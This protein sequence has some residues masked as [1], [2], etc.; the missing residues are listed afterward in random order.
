MRTGVLGS[1]T[2]RGTGRETGQWQLGDR[3]RTEAD[4]GGTRAGKGFSRPL[5]T[6]PSAGSQASPHA[7][8]HL[9]FPLACPISLWGPA[10]LRPTLA[11][12]GPT[13][14]CELQS[15][16]CWVTQADRVLSQP[17]QTI[18]IFSALRAGAF[19]EPV[20]LR[21]GCLADLSCPAGPGSALSK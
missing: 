5:P 15:S 13:T 1:G 7:R 16:G 4:G 11:P 19:P 2:G 10:S 9:S 14:R 18:G 3:R 20:S 12:W 17:P 21:R 8:P 6:P